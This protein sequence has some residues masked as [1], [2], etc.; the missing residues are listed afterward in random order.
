MI[1]S[2]TL[3]EA[4][5]G[6]QEAIN[7]IFE[8]FGAILKITSKKY[9]FYGCDKEDVFQEAMIGLLTAIEH[10]KSDRLASFKTF[11][12]L[13]INRH[14]ISK[15]IHFNSKKN[16]NL[17]SS[18]STSDLGTEEYNQIISKNNSPEEICFSNDKEI[19]LKTSLEKSLSKSEK[20]I[21][22]YMLLEM[23]YNEIY[24]K[25]K[26]NSKNIDNAIQRV[27]RKVRSSICDYENAL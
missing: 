11:A 16:K 20:E 23:N 2:K 19:Y 25:T 3:R 8:T 22:K 12:I 21:Y 4:K 10:Y 15:A 26:R 27:K 17:N 9:F 14:L 1:N 5:Q 24:L 7:H 13:C 6:N 18:I